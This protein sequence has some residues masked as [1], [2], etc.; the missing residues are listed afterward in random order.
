MLDIRNPLD[1]PVFHSLQDA[2]QW[3]LPMRAVL[4]RHGRWWDS[5][6]RHWLP[7][8]CCAGRPDAS[9]HTVEKTLNSTVSCVLV[10]ALKTKGW[11]SKFCLPPREGLIR[12]GRE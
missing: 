6:S 5:I 2:T 12:Q 4:S 10:L 3:C 7:G 8:C 1:G 9:E 11:I